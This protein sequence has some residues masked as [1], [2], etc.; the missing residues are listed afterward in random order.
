MDTAPTLKHP[1][2][3][4][5]IL[6]KLAFGAAIAAV[7]VGIAIQFVPVK[8]VGSNP[9][10]RY[11]LDAPPEV[12]AILRRAC[13]DCHSNE[14]RWPLYARIAPGSWLMADD[15]RK[16]RSRMNMSEW[17]EAE[18]SE[19]TLDKE[20]AWEQIEEGNMPP[21]VY[22]FPFH[23]DARLSERDKATLKAWLVPEKKAA[24]SKP[25]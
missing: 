14:T 7:V 13:M 2:N 22:I 16:G 4:K 11:Q 3:R 24:E 21:Q 19:R 25:Q 12:Q 1:S 8:G 5:Q 20:N 17:G 6:R 18:E 9:P 10:E 23:L 15:V